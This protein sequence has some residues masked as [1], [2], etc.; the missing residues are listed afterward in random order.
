MNEIYKNAFA[1][2]QE[3][4]YDVSKPTDIS[5]EQLQ[6]SINDAKYFVEQI[7]KYLSIYNQS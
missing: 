6:A 7:E 3:S 5:S 1:D 4:D 2:R